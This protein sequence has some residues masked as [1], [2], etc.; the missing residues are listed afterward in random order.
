MTMSVRQ[1]R[2]YGTYDRIG[3]LLLWNENVNCGFSC[4]SITAHK[5]SIHVVNKFLI[6]HGLLKDFNFDYALNFFF[7]TTRL[8][9]TCPPILQNK[10]KKKKNS[11]LYKLYSDL[12]L[13]ILEIQSIQA[14]LN[15]DTRRFEDGWIAAGFPPSS[16][17]Q[18][19][20]LGER[21]DNEKFLYRQSVA[22]ISGYPIQ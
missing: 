3:A 21:R 1:Y 15:A 17:L 22:G 4:W 14:P 18:S 19:N 6:P 12:F 8:S 2:T 9:L 11:L 10:I 20:P 13:N 16:F 7:S 5:C